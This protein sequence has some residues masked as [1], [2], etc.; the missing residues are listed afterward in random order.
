VEDTFRVDRI[1]VHDSISFS[2]EQLNEKVEKTALDHLE[3][4]E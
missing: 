3:R 2:L 1:V 4:F